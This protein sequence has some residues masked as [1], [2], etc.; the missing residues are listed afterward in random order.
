MCYFHANEI[1]S[2]YCLRVIE[3]RNGK[4]RISFN[5]FPLEGKFRGKWLSI[6]LDLPRFGE[7]RRSF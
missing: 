5:A 7:K 3:L 4:I 1:G 2:K 6:A